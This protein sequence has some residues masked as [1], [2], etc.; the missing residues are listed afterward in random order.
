MS[1]IYSIEGISEFRRSFEDKENG[2]NWH[3][4]WIDDRCGYK[5]RQE[6]GEI[7]WLAINAILN[8]ALDL[9]QNEHTIAVISLLD[10]ALG[11]VIRFRGEPPL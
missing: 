4:Q 9:N 2:L 6:G 3:R 1:D 11:N 5:K 10:E 8:N 7:K